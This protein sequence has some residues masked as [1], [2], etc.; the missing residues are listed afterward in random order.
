MM[1][2]WDLA[3]EKHEPQSF[4]VSHY[5]QQEN[6]KLTEYELKADWMVTKTPFALDVV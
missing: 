5:R 2:P 6:L 1:S 3:I 4:N